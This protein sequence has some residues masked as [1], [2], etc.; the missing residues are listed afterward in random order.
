MK[1]QPSL[2]FRQASPDF[3]RR[4][5]DLL[6]SI[7]KLSKGKGTKLG[8]VHS[9]RPPELQKVLDFIGGRCW[10]RT[11]D[12]RLVRP[13]RGVGGSTK[14]R[15]FPGVSAHPISSET[16]QIRHPTGT[17]TGTRKT[18]ENLEAVYAAEQSLPM[19][20]LYT[21]FLVCGRRFRFEHSTTRRDRS[22]LGSALSR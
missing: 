16:T 21:L 10:F 4:T 12:P 15:V 1:M 5:P 13:T 19:K 20:R 2:D 9:Q 6:R 22:L 3:G 7:R 18:S 8:T 14:I 11:S 17:K